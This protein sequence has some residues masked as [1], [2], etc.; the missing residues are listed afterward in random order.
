MRSTNFHDVRLFVDPPLAAA[1]AI[2]CTPEQANYLLNVLRLGDRRGDPHLQRQRRRM[3][4]AHRRD[5]QAALHAGM[6]GAD[7]PAAG[8]PGRAL[9]LRPAEARAP[10]LHGA[11]GDRDGRCASAAGADASHRRRARQPRAHARQRHRGCRAMRRVARADGGRAVEARGGARRL[12]SRAP[13]DFLRRGRRRGE[14]ARGAVGRRRIG[15]S[16]SSSDRKAASMP[17]SARCCAS[18]PFALPISLGP[19]IMRADTAAVAALAL[20]NAVLGDW[21]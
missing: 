20:V 19:R 21:R 14:P 8:R 2:A 4:G 17:P 18:K 6:P 5:R 3:A 9:S 11:E 1:A 13:A 12:G 16:P 7:A 10:R 15:R